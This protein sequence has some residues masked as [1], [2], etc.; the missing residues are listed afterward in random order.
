MAELRTKDLADGVEI[1]RTGTWNG[2]TYTRD[3]LQDMVNNFYALESQVKP[4]LKLG[5]SEDQSLLRKEGLPAAGWIKGLKLSGDKLIAIIR[6]VP[7]KVYE[8]INKR[9]Y[10]RVSAEIYPL[11]KE[12]KSGKEF[13]NV[14]RAV[15][16]L[17]ADVPAIDSLQDIVQLYKQDETNQPYRVYGSPVCA[18]PKTITVTYS[19][20]AFPTMS[21]GVVVFKRGGQ[22]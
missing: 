15:A 7:E 17:G 21:P 16:F 19:K 14:L 12:W 18:A 8:L 1:F 10:A 22:L 3:D 20:E 4:P 2:D 5:H 6:D 13:K 9:A 11:Y